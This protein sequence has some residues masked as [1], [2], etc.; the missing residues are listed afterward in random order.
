MF[1]IKVAEINLLVETTAKNDT[2]F[3]LNHILIEGDVEK[4]QITFVATDGMR[5]IL[6][7]LPWDVRT[8]ENIRFFIPAE[9]F[10]KIA[11][12]TKTEYGFLIS[13]EKL[14]I[15]DNSD[16]QGISYPNYQDV[17]KG[18][19]PNKKRPVLIISPEFKMNVLK[20]TAI[21]LQHY[22]KIAT[23]AR[24]T[25][26]YITFEQE[27]KTS[28][29]IAKITYSPQTNFGTPLIK[30]KNQTEIL[31]LIMPIIWENRR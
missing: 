19:E 20:P 24:V 31:Y 22:T 17:L 27:N 6:L 7:K 9:D 2:H 11:K 16:R 13:T 4:E 25:G 12:S 5:L 26:E 14:K 23:F 28:P 3:A 8:K 15:F 10:N 30:Q 18:A 29:A 1:K 21:N